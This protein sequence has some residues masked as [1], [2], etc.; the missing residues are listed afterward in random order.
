ML[1][2]DSICFFL[3][4][5]NCGY[6]GNG[7]SQ[8]V[9][10]Y[11]DSDNSKTIQASLVKLGIRK[12]GNVLKKSYNLFVQILSIPKPVLQWPTDFQSCQDGSSWV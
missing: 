4:R 12:S 1:I 6:Y 10:K 11:M 2:I 8:N 3:S 5:E 9:S 7:N